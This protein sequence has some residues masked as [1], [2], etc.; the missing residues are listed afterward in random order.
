MPTQI[1]QQIGSPRQRCQ[2]QRRTM[3]GNVAGLLSNLLR[4]ARLPSER[5]LCAGAV[6]IGLAMGLCAFLVDVALETLNNWK[7]GAVKSVTR[8]RGGFWQPYL[9]FLAFCLAYS[10]GRQSN[11]YP[12][13][14]HQAAE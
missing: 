10:G 1:P 4:I 3:A 12:L 11:I 6:F 2:P 5:W 13:V 9:T 8:D 7:F 14:L